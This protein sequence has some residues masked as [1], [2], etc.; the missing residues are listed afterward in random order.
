MNLIVLTALFCL[1]SVAAYRILSVLPTVTKSHYAPQGKLI[2]GLLERGHEVVSISPYEEKDVTANYTW[3]HVEI[4]SL[5][6]AVPDLHK[7]SMVKLSF[8]DRQKIVW[9]SL[10]KYVNHIVKLP[11]LKN[12]IENDQSHFDIV[13]AEEFF[14][15]IFFVFSHKY[16]APLIIMSSFGSGH[17]INQYMGDALELSYVPHEFTNIFGY[18]N[19]YERAR[20]VINT[21]YDIIGREIYVVRKQNAIVRDVF[22]DVQDV[23]YLG[24]LERNAS[25]MF[26]NSHYSLSTVKPSLPNIVEIGGIHMDKVKPLSK[27]IQNVLDGATDGAILFSFGSVMEL[28]KQSSEMVAKIMET[29]GKF[30]QRVL[31]KWN[32]ENDIPNKPKNVYPFSWLPQ[33]DILAHPKVVLFVTHGG[34]LSAMETVYHG[35]PV[36]CLPFY[37]DQHRNCDRGV[38]MGY[39][40]LV[41]LEKIDTDL[42]K[43]MERVLSDPSFR[44]NIKSLSERFR[45]RQ[46]PVLDT[47]VYWVEY[48][49]RHRGMPFMSSPKRRLYWFQYYFIDVIVFTLTTLWLAVKICAKIVA[50][51]KGLVKVKTS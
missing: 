49:A 34:L 44:S 42:H 37:G 23:P 17:F 45:D 25:L 21:V 19:L 16:N 40:L 6:E 32:G 5:V 47:A 46:N 48:C 43:S 9:D 18:L 41:E 36:V 30:K 4:G 51:L 7:T 26:L 31:L 20:N 14:Q 38:K 12:F 29:L 33:N 50:R 3:V 15:P 35:V 11:K 22:K 28:S 8:F 2:R 10:W 27:E 13:I 39:G 1:H 24:D